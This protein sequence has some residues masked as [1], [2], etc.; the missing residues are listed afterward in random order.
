M[1]DL[2]AL[3]QKLSAIAAKEDIFQ[4]G[5]R[6]IS[7]GGVPSPMNALLQA[8][9]ETVLERKLTFVAGKHTINVIAA[10]RRLRGISS[11]SPSAG[12][13][14]HLAGKTIA[15]EEPALVDDAFALLS[16]TVGSASKLVVHSLPPDAFGKGGER[17]ISAEGLALLWQIDMDEAP[18]PPM[19]RFLRS[20]EQGITAALHVSGGEITASQGDVQE[21]QTIWDTQVE[22]FIEQQGVT[23][24]NTDGPQLVALDGALE[25][26]SA[27][28]LA[29]AGDDVALLVYDPA[30]I[31]DL[32]A[33]WQAIFT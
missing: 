10:G 3:A 11:A 13:I 23:F 15:R 17:G 22:S 27:A 32:H 25:D 30:T 7:Q 4:S 9:D 1:S 8:I 19:E 33:S 5:A 20:N 31:G 14:S 12:D 24:A 21:L 26:G 28:A 16:E 6:V 2:N 29:L 18:L